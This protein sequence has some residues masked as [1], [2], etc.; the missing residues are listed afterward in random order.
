MPLYR[1]RGRVLGGPFPAL[2]V[3]VGIFQG[4]YEAATPA[5]AEEKARTQAGAGAEVTSVVE[6]EPPVM[7]TRWI[8]DEDTTAGPGETHE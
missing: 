1:I 5:E 6:I 4:Q 8:R 2:R 7:T 3:G